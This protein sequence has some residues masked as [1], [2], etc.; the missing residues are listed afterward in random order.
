MHALSSA[1]I[2]LSLFEHSVSR[3]EEA[4]TTP[5]NS[6][7]DFVTVLVLSRRTRSAFPAIVNLC[8]SL[9]WIPAARSRWADLS[10]PPSR[11]TVRRGEMSPTIDVIAGRMDPIENSFD[12]LITTKFPSA[13]I[14]KIVIA[15]I[16]SDQ[17]GDFMLDPKSIRRISS[18]RNVLAPTAVTTAIAPFDTEPGLSSSGASVPCSNVVPAKR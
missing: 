15:A 1:P 5:L 6:S 9:E 2:G 18:P 13:R 8:T 12:E 17:N 4:G 14:I 10:S 7:P 16:N 3:R 11:A